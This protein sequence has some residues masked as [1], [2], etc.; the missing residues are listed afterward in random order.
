MS[1]EMFDNTAAGRLRRRWND[2]AEEMHAMLAARAVRKLATI[3]PLH[4]EE[5]IAVRVGEFTDQAE[6][7][8]TRV[9]RR[10]AQLAKVVELS[11]EVTT[12]GYEPELSTR[13]TR[14]VEAFAA[15]EDHL[16]IDAL[17]DSR[18][19]DPAFSDELAPQVLEGACR[20][21]TPG[22]HGF[23]FVYGSSHRV[24]AARRVELERVVGGGPVVATGALLPRQAFLLGSPRP[25]TLYVAREA[26]FEL[27]GWN[28]YT[29]T[30]ALTERVACS[31]DP[32]ARLEQI[33][34]R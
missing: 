5:A 26:R 8:R 16:L 25:L 24:D 14:L 31:V 7:H 9:R 13:F 2:I 12:T 34:L 30:V 29:A 4:D 33:E 15:A 6:V 18:P 23:G 28:R 11:H 32:I 20:G 22:A 27:L 1:P 17:L 19:W 10:D 3:Q 21:E